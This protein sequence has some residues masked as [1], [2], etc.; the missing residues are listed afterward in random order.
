AGLPARL[1]PAGIEPPAG[2]TTGDLVASET[3]EMDRT[4]ADID[5]LAENDP[6]KMAAF[7]R[8]LM[9]DRQTV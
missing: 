6:E 4:R 3:S 1:A 9:D 5:A 2:L 7:L 8:G